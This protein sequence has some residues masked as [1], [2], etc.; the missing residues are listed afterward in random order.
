MRKLKRLWILVEE[1]KYGPIVNKAAIEA[2]LGTWLQHS[3]LTF[4]HLSG[5]K[6]S[7]PRMFGERN[8]CVK[9]RWK[10]PL[11]AV[12]VSRRVFSK[13]KLSSTSRCED[14]REMYA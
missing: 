11:H 8:E 9:W 4:H 14:E 6:V 2:I 3:K 10:S 5:T 12:T 1:V 13:W 7:H